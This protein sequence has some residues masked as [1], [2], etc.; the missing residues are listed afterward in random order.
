VAA[1]LA[2]V[3]LPAIAGL[4]APLSAQRPVT[5][6][7]MG[8]YVQNSPVWNRGFDTESVGGAVL[9]AWVNVPTPLLWLSVTAEATLTQRG[10]GTRLD[11]GEVPGA[12]GVSPIRTDYLTTSV[13]PRATLEVGPLR[14]HVATG[15]TMDLL[16][17]SREDVLPEPLLDEPATAVFAWTAGAGVGADVGTGWVAEIEARIVEGLSNAYSG[18]LGTLRNR[19]IEILARVGVKR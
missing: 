3:T 8:G 11:P 17:R 18:E 16:L 4:G 12:L 19:S 14:L 13:L 7:G 15:P 2:L 10:S 9:G 6:G 5:L 1:F